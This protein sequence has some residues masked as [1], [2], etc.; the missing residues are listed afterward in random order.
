M[1]LVDVDTCNG[2]FAWN[3]KRGGESQ[4][5]SRFDRFIIFGNLMLSNKEITASVLPVGDSN[6]WPIQMEIQDIGTP[7]IDLLDLRIIGCHTQ[8]SLEI[9][10]NGG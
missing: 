3:N 9:L 4:V 7:R 8:T 5:A 1:K 10:G 2:L 6:H